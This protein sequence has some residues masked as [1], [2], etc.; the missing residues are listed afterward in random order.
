SVVGPSEF[1]PT[2][3]ILVP[4]S[5]R[6]AS[7]TLD[8]ANQLIQADD[9]VTY[10]APNFLAEVRKRAV[11]DPLFASQW[12]LDN[13]GQNGGRSQQDV[14]ALAAWTRIGGGH[15][16]IV[17]A[18]IDDGIDLDHPDLAPNIWKNPKRGARD[19]HGRDFVDDNDR[20]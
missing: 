15:S 2:R 12:H 18:I 4:R 14:G 3:L 13:S 9:L 16:S 7:R 11:N 6:R 5:V 20:F 10:A 17:I 19:R 8:L 1:D